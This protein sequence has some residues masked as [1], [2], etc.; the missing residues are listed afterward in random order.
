VYGVAFGAAGGPAAA[1]A[2]HPSAGGSVDIRAAV[3]MDGLRTE[4]SSARITIE[5][6]A[7]RLPPLN[8][9]NCVITETH[10]H[11][12]ADTPK[13][14]DDRLIPNPQERNLLSGPL[15]PVVPH[16]STC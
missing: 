13:Q 10:P 6:N 16:P 3:A 8:P 7:A 9:A 14:S 11:W 4:P 12:R 2:V 1:G 5:A 15:T